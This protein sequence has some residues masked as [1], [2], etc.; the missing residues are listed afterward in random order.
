MTLVPGALDLAMSTTEVT[1]AQWDACY[2]EM[3]C[4]RYLSDDGFGRGDRPAGNMTWLDALEYT[5]WLSGKMGVNDPCITVRLPSAAEWQATALF[6][7]NGPASWADA[8][9]DTQPVC[10]GCAPGDDGNEAMRVASEPANAAGLYD[11]VGNLWEWVSDSADGSGPECDL[12]A[13]RQSGQCSTG[14]VMGGSYAPRA[15]ALA[16]IATGGTAPR[17]GNDRPWSSPTVGLRVACN[18]K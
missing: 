7:S 16:S 18:V 4:H 2:R 11:M 1:Y 17:T 13:I 3:G 14:R 9:A 10:W 15:D 5:N 6:T 12:T 8:V